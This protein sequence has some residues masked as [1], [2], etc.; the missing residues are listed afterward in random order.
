MCKDG[1]RAITRGRDLRKGCAPHS[2]LSSARYTEETCDNKDRDTAEMG[3]RAPGVPRV[4][5]A[6]MRG[7][8]F[9]SQ[10]LTRFWA[11]D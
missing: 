9:V 7:C 10:T 11:G 1:G 4:L 8:K 6:R 3:E 5:N 2:R